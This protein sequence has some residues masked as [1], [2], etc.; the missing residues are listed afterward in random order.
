MWVTCSSS[1]HLSTAWLYSWIHERL[2]LRT[3]FK[4]KLISH[5]SKHFNTINRDS[6]LKL[7]KKESSRATSLDP[8]L[9]HSAHG[10]ALTGIQLAGKEIDAGRVRGDCGAAAGRVRGDRGAAAGRSRDIFP[11]WIISQCRRRDLS[12]PVVCMTAAFC[13]AESVDWLPLVCVIVCLLMN[14]NKLCCVWRASW[15][16]L[17]QDVRLGRHV[18]VR[19]YHNSW[20]LKTADY[21]QSCI[22]HLF[23]FAMLVYERAQLRTT[24]LRYLGH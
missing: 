5:K 1:T 3:T 23:G 19:R 9:Q 16:N 12:S 17:L 2:P 18:R 22:S 15:W 6:Y 14:I 7:G 4:G 24:S 11:P 10:W 8:I 20:Y 21:G 13:S